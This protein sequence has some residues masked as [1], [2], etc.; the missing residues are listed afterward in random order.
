ADRVLLETFSSEDDL[1]LARDGKL[2]GI[3]GQIRLLESHIHKSE[4]DLERRMVLIKS[5]EQ[6]GQRPAGQIL[7]DIGS[8]RGQI[9]AHQANI[10]SK[11][12]EQ[13]TIRR[14]F[15]QDLERFR[16]LAAR[17]R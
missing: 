11:R 12:R 7:A 9:A 14:R 6:R 3:D 8:T 5:I 1:I 15:D 17:R 16:K 2:S 4:A 13:D 10:E